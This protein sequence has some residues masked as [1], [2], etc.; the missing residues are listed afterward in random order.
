MSQITISN[1]TKNILDDQLLNL[2]KS[3]FT[4]SDIGFLNINYKFYIAN[5]N[6]PNNFIV[7]FDEAYKYVGFKFKHKAKDLLE[8]DFELNIDYKM[9]TQ[10]LTRP[11]ERFNGGQ[12]KEIILLTIECFAKNKIYN[13]IF[14]SII[15]IKN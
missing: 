5:K 6:N 8:K 13:F 10:A 2:I 14:G 3:N 12:N 11:G 15:N 1:D 7:D 4:E 9:N